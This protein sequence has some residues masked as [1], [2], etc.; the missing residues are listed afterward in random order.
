MMKTRMAAGFVVSMLIG[1]VGFLARGSAG[2]QR[3]YDYD[4]AGNLKRIVDV[5]SDLM[6]CGAIGRVCPAGNMCT[7]GQCVALTYIAQFDPIVMPATMAGYPV[8][9]LTMRVQN[10]GTATWTAGS[11]TQ[12]IAL[13]VHATQTGVVQPPGVVDLAI[14]STVAPGAALTFTVPLYCYYSGV[15]QFAFSMTLS[16]TPFAQPT[17][18]SSVCA[19]DYNAAQREAVRCAPY[20]RRHRPCPPRVVRPPRPQPRPRPRR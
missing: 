11:G 3:G 12:P 7:A 15:Q 6:N 5:S 10:A 20:H 13:H 2:G 4:A 1:G 14:P 9:M 8:E 16:G 19:M 18:G 17:A